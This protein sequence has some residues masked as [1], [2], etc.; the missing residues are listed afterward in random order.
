MQRILISIFCAA[1]LALTAGC[2]IQK[3]NIQ[4]GNVVDEAML[5][6]IQPGMNKRQVRFVLGTPLLTDPFHPD[7]WDY[8]YMERRHNEIQA[9]R[10]LTLY[11]SDD[12]LSKIVK[13]PENVQAWTAP[14]TAPEQPR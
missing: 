13:V 2:A 3:L 6:Q 9:R 5:K 14:V 7:R 8:V 4:Q 12:T 1:C 10:H 11:F